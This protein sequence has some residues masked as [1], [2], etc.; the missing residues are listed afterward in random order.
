M[1]KV[2]SDSV[3]Y[4]TDE[5]VME[6]LQSTQERD[7]SVTADI[8]KAEVLAKVT[9]VAMSEKDPALRDM[10]ALADYFSLHRICDWISSMASR[11]KLSSISCR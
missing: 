9:F 6:F 1:G 2:Y 11:R 3:G 10:K 7:A 5:S 4:R 8:V